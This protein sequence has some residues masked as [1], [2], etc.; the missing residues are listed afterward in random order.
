MLE[1]Y[2][3]LTEKGLQCE[4][5]I[6]PVGGRTITAMI[7]SPAADHLD[8]DPVLLLT[9]GGQSTHLLPP[10]DQPAKF[11]WERGHRVVSFPI[12]FE[13]IADNALKVSSQSSGRVYNIAIEVLRDEF[14]QGPD[15]FLV[16]IE[17]AKA[18]LK[19][20]IDRKWARPGRIVVTGI[21]RFAYLAFRLMAADDQLNI[22][23]GFA[24]VTDWRDLSEFHEQRNLKEVADLRLSLFAEKL[25]GKK[26]YMAIGSHDERV[27]TLSCCQFFLDLNKENQ[28]CGFDRTY[29]DFFCTPDPHHTCGDEWYQRGMEILLSRAL[30]KK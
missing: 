7:A 26:I 9:I 17:E 14:L 24:P 18:V 15:P 5:F 11:F 19:T 1:E 8:P 2:T 20:C 28:K 16:L 21:S 3:L 30:A 27:N 23:G 22:G 10:N 12:A 6:V 4:E 25:A 13:V 29:V